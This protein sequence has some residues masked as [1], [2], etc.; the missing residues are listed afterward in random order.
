M[1]GTNNS[2]LGGTMNRDEV[3]LLERRIQLSE[4]NE[5]S[6]TWNHLPMMNGGTIIEY[7]VVELSEVAG[8]TSE[9]DSNDLGNIIL[10]NS[11]APEQVEINGS[12]TWEDADNQDGLRPTSIT[13][14]LLADG[15][16]VAE[17]V[18]A[19][20]SDWTYSFEDLPK[21]S[22]GIEIV[23]TITE[24]HVP[25]YTTLIDGFNLSNHY[26][27]GKTNVTVTKAWNDNHDQDGLRSEYIEVQLA[28]DGKV[29]NEIVTL[30]EANAWIF[31]WTD[32]PL[33]ESGRKI[34]YSVKEITTIDGYE[35]SLD[36]SDKG[37]I[38][39]IIH[40]FQKL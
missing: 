18:V 7:N 38:I 17:Q 14:N 6:Y 16:K 3:A 36:Q 31:T 29:I 26:T 24:N 22:E 1:G 28:A 15:M 32:L 40:I 23:Y 4:L 39:L 21:F 33:K 25:E 12:K 20:E 10:T 37:N 9:I 11:H 8:Y 30:N 27:P 34:V 19:A 2:D 13:V 35:M 5:W